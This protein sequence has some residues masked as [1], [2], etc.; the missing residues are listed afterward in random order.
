MF[1]HPKRIIRLTKECCRQAYDNIRLFIA[2]HLPLEDKIVFCQHEGKGMMDDPKYI[3][4][5][6]LRRKSKVKM[7]WLLNNMN[8]PLV[9]GIKAVKYGS[10]DALCEL[11][12]AKIWVYNYKGMFLPP[13]KRKGQYY[14]QCWHGSFTPKMLE[15]D[16]EETL[17]KDYIE[18]SKADS[19]LID[20]MYSNNDFKVN[21]F[22]TRF[23]YKGQVIKSDS[24]Q[25]S[26]V[27]NPP[28]GL[29]EKVCKYFSLNSDV[30]I[31]L[32]APTL[33]SDI[34][35]YA[36]D[37]NKIMKALGEKFGGSFVMLLRIHPSVAEQ[38]KQLNYS[39][40]VIMATDYPD[41]DELLAVS[42]VLLSDYSGVAYDFA[43][44]RMPV[45]LFSKNHA[46]YIINE[47]KQYFTQE[48]LPFPMST[49]EDELIKL[50]R[51]FDNNK[52][53]HDLE[54]FYNKIGWVENGHGAENIADIIEMKLS[55]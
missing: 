31:V 26:V 2:K 4:L 6:L 22:K 55:E 3:A 42:D 32:Y 13:T 14:I 47:R 7:V 11:Y 12:T 44:R 38:S 51:E 17:P 45:F 40:R 16:T 28:Q 33:R 35:L 21:L 54:T 36:F 48:E 30:K 37:Y 29:R 34:S 9:E 46:E 52:Y 15:Q 23:W 53:I 39:Q 43:T 27:V 8:T 25:L 18:R 49:T 5:E 10:V 50:I 1:L 24:P 19:K 20:L 41:M